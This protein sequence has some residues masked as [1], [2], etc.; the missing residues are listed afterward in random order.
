METTKAGVKKKIQGLCKKYAIAEPSV[1]NY[2]EVKK[3]SEQINK[4]ADSEGWLAALAGHSNDD[5]LWK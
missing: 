3:V 4:R 1:W 5:N 2:R